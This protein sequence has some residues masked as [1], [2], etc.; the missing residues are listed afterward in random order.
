PSPAA[1]VK[2]RLALRLAGVAV[3]TAVS[4]IGYQLGSGPRAHLLGPAALPSASPKAIAPHSNE[5][6]S[7]D[8]ASS[9]AVSGRLTVGAVSPQQVDEAAKLTGSA[10][11]AGAGGAVV[12]DGLTAGSTLSAGA[13][14]GPTTWRLPVGELGGAVIPPP[15]GFVGAIDLAL[16]LRLADNTTADRKGLLLEWSGNRAPAPPAT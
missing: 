6:E 11:D 7:R 2:S 16:E 5:Q 8:A 3:V 13:Q 12:I 14:V 10:A 1:G 15:R 4:I 9:R